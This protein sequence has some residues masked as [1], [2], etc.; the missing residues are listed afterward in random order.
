MNEIVDEFHGQ[1]GAYI[2]ENGVRCRVEEP[3]KDH[4]EGNCARDKDGKVLVFNPPKAKK[5]AAASEAGPATS[6]PSSAKGGAK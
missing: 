3:T 1:G 5:P 4:P 6:A 2:L